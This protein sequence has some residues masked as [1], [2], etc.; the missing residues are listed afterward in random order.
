MKRRYRMETA[1]CRCMV[2]LGLVSLVACA[3]ETVWVEG[4]DTMLILGREWAREYREEQRGTRVRVSGGGSGR[5]IDALLRGKVDL[6][7]ASRK[8][9]D[10]EKTVF[11]KRT[12]HDPAEIVVALD[13]IGIYVHE[14]NPV[15]QLTFGQLA[16]VLNGQLTNWRLVGGYDRTIHVY[17][18]D[19]HSGTR[20]FLREHVLAGGDFAEDAQEVSTTSMMTAAVS[21]DQGG[22]GYG[23]IAYAPAAKVVKL[24]IAKDGK[25]LWPSRE[26]VSRGNY[27]LSRP[28]HYYVDPG[29]LSAAARDYLSWVLSPEGQKVVVFVGYFQ[30]PD[31]SLT[32]MR[33]RV[34]GIGVATHGGL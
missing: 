1:L 16:A 12:G 7:A 28:L 11:R 9:K 18:R 3:D 34:E 14:H 21:R 8:M 5:G 33:E 20:A 19:E 27:P 29:R 10:S 22:I 31:T 23:G 15:T 32:E 25:A 6:A 24:A 2:V 13:G 30:L 17:T 4:S 26:N